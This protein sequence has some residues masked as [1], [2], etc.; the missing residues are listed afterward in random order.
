MREHI[1]C[2]NTNI[3]EVLSVETIDAVHNFSVQGTEISDNQSDD[4]GGQLTVWLDSERAE[5]A[6]DVIELGEIAVA[7]QVISTMLTCRQY[8]SIQEAFDQQ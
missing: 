1:S 2:G 5:L 3:I 6:E 4:S 8:L 7:K